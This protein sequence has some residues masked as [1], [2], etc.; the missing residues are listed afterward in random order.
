MFPGVLD[1][2]LGKLG[3]KSQQTQE[4]VTPGRTDNL[5]EPVPGDHGPH[6]DFG[7]Q[8][9]KQSWQLKAS[10]HQVQILAGGALLGAGLFLAKRV[11]S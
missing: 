2:Y 10:L 4:P 6:G 5:W 11:K 3:Y 9:L 8:S 7:D 1:W